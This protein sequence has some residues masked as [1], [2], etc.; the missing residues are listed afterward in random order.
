MILCLLVALILPST[1]GAREPLIPRS[2]L[3]GLGVAD[4]RQ[5]VEASA[6]PWAALGRVQTELGGRCTGTLISPR[7]VLTAAHCLVAPGA[8]RWVRPSSVHF[9]LGYRRGAWR[10]EGR[11]SSF[12]T[13]P[14]FDPVSRAP[15]GADWAI[16]TLAAP[17]SNDAALT[18]IDIGS[19]PGTPL[20]LGGY[21]QDRPEILLA[22][23][24]CHLL[25]GAVHEG[26]TL[27]VHDC[28]GTRGT[29]GGPVLAR[30]SNGAWAV[31]G[32]AVAASRA[33]AL[34]L[35]VPIAALRQASERVGE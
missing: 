5:P 16:L 24:S 33:R 31:A 19:L 28:G 7:K 14:G 32:V 35:A 6:A 26:R 8:K 3:P 1:A 17:L 29:S 12:V 27:L 15:A 18:L 13:G 30:G 21:Q 22:D 34:G 11:A 23:I 2:E 9:L 25:G 20:M 4:P 10:G